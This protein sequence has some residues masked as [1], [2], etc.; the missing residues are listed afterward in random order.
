MHRL[1]VAALEG[2]PCSLGVAALEGKPCSLGVAALKGKR[3]GCVR[4]VILKK[5]FALQ[6]AAALPRCNAALL[7]RNATIPKYDPT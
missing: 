1:G 6:A 7:K 4:I 5:M 2:K 3:S